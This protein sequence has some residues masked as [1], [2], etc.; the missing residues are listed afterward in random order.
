[1]TTKRKIQ[2]TQIKVASPCSAS[3]E[4]MTGD[5]RSRFCQQ[6]EKKVFDIS[7]M[8]QDEA[9]HFLTAATGPVCVRLYRRTDGTIITNDCPVG[10][11]AVRMRLVQ[12]ATATAALIGMLF[13]TVAF[14]AFNRKSNKSSSAVEALKDM[15]LIEPTP[16][17]ISVALPPIQCVEMGQMEVVANPPFPLV[18]TLPQIAPIVDAPISETPISDV[19]DFDVPD[20][21]VPDSE[22]SAG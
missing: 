16:V 2:L 1:M 6:C 18:P 4:G 13:C 7:G 22:P 8:S 9:E 10:L 19:P 14:G 12:V 5:Q 21:D 11:R 15:S 17:P 20:F 3:W